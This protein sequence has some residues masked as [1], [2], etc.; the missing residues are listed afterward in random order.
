MTPASK[1]FRCLALVACVPGSVVASGM[2][3]HPDFQ[4]C[5]S[6]PATCTRLSLTSTSL[7]GTVP[8]ELFAATGLTSLNLLRNLLTGTVPTELAALT[9]LV[10][11]DLYRNLLTGTIPTEM[12]ALTNMLFLELHYNSLT[13]TIP[14]ELGEMTDMR[15]MCAH[16][17]CERTQEEQCA[18]APLT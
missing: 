4:S 3:S 8:S 11:L 12:A 15:W 18:P 7:T 17:P 13:G 14:T 5:I 10:S 9:N 16:A 1:S 2:S 6:N